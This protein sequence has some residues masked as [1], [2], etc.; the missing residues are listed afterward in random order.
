MDV[1]HL[2]ATR[3]DDFASLLETIPSVA[4]FIAQQNS[5]AGGAY[6][7]DYQPPNVLVDV[8]GTQ[9]G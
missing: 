1:I 3:A 8:L 6:V 2:A 7:V 5:E 4:A 9:G